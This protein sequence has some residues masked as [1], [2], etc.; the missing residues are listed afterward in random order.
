LWKKLK[1]SPYLGGNLQTGEYGQFIPQKALY[2]LFPNTRTFCGIELF[3]NNY[4]DAVEI[5]SFLRCKFE[6]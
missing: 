1:I 6:N 2:A 5:K 4:Q 3:N